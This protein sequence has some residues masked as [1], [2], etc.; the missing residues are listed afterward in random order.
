MVQ[1]LFMNLKHRSILASER[2]PCFKNSS[3]EYHFAED[4]LFEIRDTLI[5]IRES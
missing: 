5:F 3:C 2:D 4:Q 1:K